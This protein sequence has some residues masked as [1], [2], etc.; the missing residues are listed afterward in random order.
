M[1]E[2]MPS[3]TPINAAGLLSTHQVIAEKLYDPE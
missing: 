1:F 3:G 2:K